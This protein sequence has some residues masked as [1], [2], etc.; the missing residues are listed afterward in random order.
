MLQSWLLLGKE[1]DNENENIEIGEVFP[2]FSWDIFSFP[3]ITSK[4]KSSKL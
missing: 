3:Y 4:F 2:R 1:N